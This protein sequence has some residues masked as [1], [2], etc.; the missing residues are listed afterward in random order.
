MTFSESI[1]TC[2]GKFATF[3]GRASRSEYWWFYLFTLLLSWGASLVGATII[4]GEAG[5]FLSI[6]VNLVLL[7]PALAAGTRRLH[8]TGRSGWWQLL[9]FTVIGGILIIVW[10]ATEGT[11]ESNAH[12]EP[13]PLGNA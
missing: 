13:I 6:I 7:I 5:G 12:G 9:Y 11:K 1:S 3:S 10:Q 4:P 8:D 2:M